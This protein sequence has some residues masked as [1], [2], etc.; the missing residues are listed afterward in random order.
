M[1]CRGHT[2]IN[3]TNPQIQLWDEIGLIMTGTTTVMGTASTAGS[4]GLVRNLRSGSVSE[5]LFDTQDSNYI[6]SYQSGN[7]DVSTIDQIGSDN[8]VMYQSEGQGANSDISQIGDDNYVNVIQDVYSVGN[9]SIFQ[10]GDENSAIVEQELHGSSS[11]I[12]Q[13]GSNNTG[14]ARVSGK[15]SLLGSWC[16]REEVLKFCRYG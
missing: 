13:F 9:S 5:G 6:D 1:G 4:S 14:S 12:D 2:Q 8:Y 3:W 7:G 11:F 10:V 16:G 15:N